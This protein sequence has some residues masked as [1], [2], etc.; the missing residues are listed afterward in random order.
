MEA[1]VRWLDEGPEANEAEVE[2]LLDEASEPDV[3]QARLA[4]D[5]RTARSASAALSTRRP[6]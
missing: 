4:G 1:V 3:R 5:A 6:R 2:E